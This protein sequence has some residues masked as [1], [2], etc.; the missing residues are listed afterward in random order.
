MPSQDTRTSWLTVLLATACGF[1][2]L[3]A[4]S[5]HTNRISRAVRDA[6]CP[7]L[8]SLATAGDWIRSTS[9]RLERA[10]AACRVVPSP[11]GEAEERELQLAALQEECRRLSAANVQLQAE[12]EVAR[13]TSGSPFVAEQGT[14]LFVPELLES[15]IIT[16]E[17]N[18]FD[19]Q[20]DVVRPV[21]GIGSRDGVI[22]AEF[23]IA[24]S[25]ASSSGASAA[26]T[27]I[28]DQGAA[29]GLA[30]D[31]PVFAGR[32]VVGKVQQVGQWASTVLSI[33]DPTYRGGAQL[34][35][36]T[37]RGLVLG[38][39]GVLT[40]DGQ[41]R[42]RLTLI[43]ATEPVATGDEVYTSVRGAALPAPM[44]YG[45]VV[46][47]TLPHGAPHWEIVVQ[48][49]VTGEEIRSVHVLRSVVNPQRTGSDPSLED[50][51]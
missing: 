38:H 18:A 11:P 19:A 48:P 32:S 47:A 25:S 3:L 13:Q 21:L 29:E 20:P 1:G 40:G 15:R 33:T 9:P 37:P 22:P 6:A 28:I 34:V 46:T 10:L 27:R 51:P 49:A 5:P 44:Y 12:L 23:V 41:G 43:P 36:S 16:L 2:L 24:A 17:E 7:G 30:A 31:Q 45:R 50:L 26:V 4:P 39:E 8:L 14:P 35:R 42:C